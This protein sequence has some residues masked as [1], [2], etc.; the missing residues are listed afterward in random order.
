MWMVARR[1]RPVW[2]HQSPPEI[3]LRRA[4][5]FYRLPAPLACAVKMA[6]GTLSALPCPGTAVP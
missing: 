2:R 5:F 4:P 3:L 1:G 6:K